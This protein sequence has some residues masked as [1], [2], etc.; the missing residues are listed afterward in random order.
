MSK[1]SIDS[2]IDN[3]QD[4][5]GRISDKIWDYAETRFQEY[6]SVDLLCNTLEAEGFSI[7]K[8]IAN[9]STAF[10]ATWGTGSPVIALLAEYDALSGLSQQPG[11]A[12]KTVLPNMTNGHG[13]GH[14]L[15]GVGSLGAA[16]AVKEYIEKHHLSGT[17]R[18][19]GCPGEEGGSGKTFM[20]R[21][22]VFNDVDAAFCW[23]PQDY[24]AVLSVHS[25]A[26]AQILYKFHG[27]SAHAAASPHLGRSALD[28]VELMNIGANFLREH[29]IP[30]ARLHYAI[31]DAGGS[32]PNVVQPTASALY[33]IR[34]P[35]PDQVREIRERVNDIAKGAALMTGT[36]VEII[37]HKACS[38]LIPNQTLE[39]LLY[40]N[41]NNTP[42]PTLNE[43]END[44]AKL[45]QGTFSENDFQANFTAMQ[46]YAPEQS[47]DIWRNLS[48]KQLNDF[49]L[50]YQCG[51]AFLSGSSDVGDV[52]WVVPTAQLATACL[53]IGTPA[54]SWQQTAQGKCNFAK[55]GMY[56]AAKVMAKS[57]IDVLLNPSHLTAAKAELKNK[58]QRSPYKN[59]I[60]SHVRPMIQPK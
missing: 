21:D 40:E 1:S 51:R 54:H 4:F 13:C 36:S 28:A 56:C 50:P 31:T 27:K 5:L 49:I 11:I 43:T 18:Y 59:P 16:I 3:R 10:I 17:I 12:N 7:E 44:F 26:N 33:L 32:A 29:I 57:I 45:L 42:L 6:Q 46:N 24:N 22:G 19:Y 47:N 55:S 2:I 48:N 60:P 25:L 23:H 37:F 30:E 58:T 35:Q 20:V 52:S 53:V 8:N 41:L 15:L 34:A 39:T 38:N 14:N 9:I